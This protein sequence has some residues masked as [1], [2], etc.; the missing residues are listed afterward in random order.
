[1]TATVTQLQPPSAGAAALTRAAAA[2]ALAEL[3][4]ATAPPCRN[5][6]AAA[7]SAIAGTRTQLHR[8]AAADQITLPVLAGHVVQALC[9]TLWPE[10]DDEAPNPLLGARAALRAALAHAERR[11]W[12]SA[13]RMLAVATAF[14]EL[15]LEGLHP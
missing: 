3:A 1:M 8:A 11:D 6:I 9:R 10:C 5:A 4:M 7:L 14:L 13:H 2:G 15:A 12:L